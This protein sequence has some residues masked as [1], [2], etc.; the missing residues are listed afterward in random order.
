MVNQI[1]KN[2]K[3]INQRLLMIEQTDLFKSPPPKPTQDLPS[4]KVS[5]IW[6]RMTEANI[7]LLHCISLVGLLW[8]CGERACT[9]LWALSPQVPCHWTTADQSWRSGGS[10]QHWE[11]SQTSPVLCLLGEE[12]LQLSYQGE[13]CCM[14]SLLKLTLNSNLWTSCPVDCGQSEEL[15]CC[16][17][18][19]QAIVPSGDP[20]GC[21]WCG[22][23]PRC[24]WGL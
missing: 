21:S 11:V 22:A 18:L 1:Q 9:W 17:H 23:S 6:C 2:S 3:D 19:W 7:I 16:C 4:C 5:S 15:Q 12:D 10:H 13:A 20:F 14:T 8:V 24:Q